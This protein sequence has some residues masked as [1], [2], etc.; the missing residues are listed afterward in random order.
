[1]RAGLFLAGFLALDFPAGFFLAAA[2]FLAGAFFLAAGRCG[3]LRIFFAAGFFTVLRAAGLAA[4]LAGFLR[5][6]FLGAAFLGVALRTLFL[7][8]ALRA[9]GLVAS[10]FFAAL[11]FAAGFFLLT[12]ISMLLSSVQAPSWMDAAALRRTA[13]PAAPLS[14]AR[15]DAQRWMKTIDA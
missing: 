5:V 8:G 13:E 1:L 9:A 6:L 11:F 4:F 2:D 14:P 12:A 7:A 15:N 10:F 3:F